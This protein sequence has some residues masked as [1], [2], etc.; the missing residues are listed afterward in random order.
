MKRVYFTNKKTN[1]TNDCRVGNI[2]ELIF[3]ITH[4]VNEMN[5]AIRWCN[6]HKVG[7]KFDKNLYSIEIIS[8]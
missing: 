3:A 6:T 7:D 2:G 1:A 8:E 5:D 4:D